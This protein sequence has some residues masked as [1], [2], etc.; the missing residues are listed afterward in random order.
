MTGSIV[1]QLARWIVGWLYSRLVKHSG[2]NFVSEQYLD[3]TP[4]RNSWFLG[5]ARTWM[6]F[7]V[8]LDSVKCGPS[9][10]GFIVLVSVSGRAYPRGA[11]YISGDK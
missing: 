10:G 8:E 3:S 4:L 7:R 5:L 9:T 2:A 6:L 1:G 11:A